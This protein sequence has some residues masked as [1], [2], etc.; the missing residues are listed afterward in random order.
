[1]LKQPHTEPNRQMPAIHKSSKYGFAAV[2]VFPQSLMTSRL[3][4]KSA[5]RHTD[6]WEAR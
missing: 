2:A 6:I 3:V 5:V 4:I 1:M